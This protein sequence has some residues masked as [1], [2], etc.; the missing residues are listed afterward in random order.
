MCQRQKLDSP[1]SKC[2]GWFNRSFLTEIGDQAAGQKIQKCASAKERSRSLSKSHTLSP[3]FPSL[4]NG[5]QL[6]HLRPLSYPIN[7]HTRTAPI[8][9]AKKKHHDSKV[10]VW[11]P[12]S[13]FFPHL[14]LLQIAAS[15]HKPPVKPPIWLELPDWGPQKNRT[16]DRN[17]RQWTSHKEYICWRKSF[18]R[19]DKPSFQNGP[20]LKIHGPSALQIT[21][22]FAMAATAF[23]FFSFSSFS[24][25]SVLSFFTFSFCSFFNSSK[26]TPVWQ[27]FFGRVNGARLLSLRLAGPE[28]PQRCSWNSI[29]AIKLGKFCKWG[30]NL[31]EK[32]F[33]FRIF[34]QK[35]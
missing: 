10:V 34:V 31:Y 20:T 2:F 6:Q 12:L 29:V 18:F 13:S 11:L 25:L 15:H 5:W 22:S 19:K 16:T 14:C 24:A 7:D 26:S 9:L 27:S 17:Q 4:G 30:S 33:F 23:S 1:N 35:E 8:K 3:L 32:Q 21:K 28:T